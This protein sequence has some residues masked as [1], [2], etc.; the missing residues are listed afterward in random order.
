MAPGAAGGHG[1]SGTTDTA[2][3]G[4]ESFWGTGRPLGPVWVLPLVGLHT[5][6]PLLLALMLLVVG[7]PCE[8]SGCIHFTDGEIEAPRGDTPGL[9]E[10]ESE[11]KNH[12]PASPHHPVG[13]HALC[14]PM[15]LGEGPLNSKSVSSMVMELC[16]H[17]HALPLGLGNGGATWCPPPQEVEG[18]MKLGV[19]ANGK[20]LSI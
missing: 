13:L 20:A 7:P 10:W 3:G 6:C 16:P 9:W 5:L 2:S 11:F 12:L 1:V 14:V 8:D 18:I 15:G 4:G 17:L 19:F